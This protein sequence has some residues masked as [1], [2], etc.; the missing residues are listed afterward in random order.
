VSEGRTRMKIAIPE[1]MRHLKIDARGYPIPSMVL[2]D[3][4]GRPHFAIND[5]AKRQRMIRE[6]LCSI[7]GTKLFRGRWFVGGALSAFHPHGAFLDP[8][9]HAEC[10]RFALQVC[11]YLA[12][13]RYSAE[14]GIAKAKAHANALTDSMV[15]VDRTMMPG[16]PH[17][18]LF[19]ALMTTRRIQI[20][21]N[22]NLKPTPPYNAV[23]YWRRGQRLSDREGEAM[24][25]EAIKSYEQTEAMTA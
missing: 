23:E 11:P 6:E 16:R 22:T 17:E 18:D 25:A 20:F 14:I 7:C 15:L 9:M 19:I 12:A 24:V 8:P 13:P 3:S 5:E 4:A 1:R 2:I 10:S 21:D